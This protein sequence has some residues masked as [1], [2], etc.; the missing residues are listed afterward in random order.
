MDNA[1]LNKKVYVRDIKRA[2][3]LNQV[4][5]DEKSLERWV[6]A[7]DI[8][9]P[10]L[11]LA[12]YVRPNDLKRI[13]IIGNKEMD[14]IR[15]LPKEVL[16]GRFESITDAYTPCIIMTGG[17]HAPELLLEIAQ[18]RNFPVFE[19][20]DYT[21]RFV[22]QVIAYLDERLAPSKS[23]HAVMM[24]I[25]GV[26]VMICGESGIGKSELALELI[27]RGHMLVADDC[28]EVYRIHND[29][30]CTPPAILKNML[31][32]RGVGV[33]DVSMAFGSTSTLD[34]TVLDLIINLVPFNAESI[35]DR[36]GIE[37]QNKI[38][39]LGVEK[40]VY[41]IPIKEG[42]AMGVIVE[43]AVANYRLAEKGIDS[44]KL[45]DQRVME[46]MK[47]NQENDI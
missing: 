33:I 31:E 44:A 41:D 32:I 37:R 28:V 15:T 22:V 13:T 42:R 4:S 3:K 43:S 23:M 24:D 18:E 40:P 30:I 12:G 21:H 1:V 26:G 46:F 5:G 2:F 11:E 16:K 10:G 9:R 27:R 8:N 14:F 17:N 25:Y 36:I 6:I 39:I 29:I 34:K 45:F 35:T 20:D 19:M 47:K 7:P 38:D